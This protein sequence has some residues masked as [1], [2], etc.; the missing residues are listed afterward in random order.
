MLDEHSQ[1]A[2]YKIFRAYIKHE[3]SLIH[4]RLSW[5]INIQALLFAA[6]YYAVVNTMQTVKCDPGQIA[7]NSIPRFTSHAFPI[8]AFG[9][10]PAIGFVI[11]LFSLIGVVAARM[12]IRQVE[13]DWKKFVLRV[14]DLNDKQAMNDAIYN[15]RH[16]FPNLTGGSHPWA[17]KLGF[18]APIGTPAIFAIAWLVVGIVELR[19]LHPWPHGC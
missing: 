7:S 14:K 16:F 18:W 3:D 13:M 10:I 9:L 11:S 8:F 15:V 17:R 12:A 5:N 6:Y 1:R 2:H 4:R 19:L